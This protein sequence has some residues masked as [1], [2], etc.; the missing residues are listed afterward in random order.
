M[1]DSPGRDRFLVDEMLNH[2]EVVAANVRKGRD[3]FETDATPRYAIEHATELFAEAAEKIGHQFKS[4]NPHLPWDRLRE[5][6]RGLAHP[7]DARGD[8]TYIEQ[9]WRFAQAELP[10]IVRRLRGAKFPRE[11]GP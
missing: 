4:T 5:L 8:S 10:A 3:V 2:A 6:R 9:T 11:S 7:Y 1:K